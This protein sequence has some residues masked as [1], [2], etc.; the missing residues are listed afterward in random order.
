MKDNTIKG[1]YEND[2]SILYIGRGELNGDLIPGKIR[3]KLG[4]LNVPY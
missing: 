2:G 1:G 3:P 4:G